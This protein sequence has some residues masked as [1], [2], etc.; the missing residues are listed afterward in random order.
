MSSLIPFK[1]EN[2]DVRVVMIAV[3]VPLLVEPAEK[4][5]GVL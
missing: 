2:H 3:A 5:G 1:F 4:T